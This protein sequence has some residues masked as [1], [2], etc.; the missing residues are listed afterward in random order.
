MD[1]KKIT[2]MDEASQKSSRESCTGG[3]HNGKK[4]GIIGAVLL[5]LIALIVGIGIYNTPSN[6]L[7]WQLDLGNR[8]LKEQNYEQAIVEF[9]KAIAID[10]VSVDAYLGKAEAYI[11]MGDQ[12]SALDT[13]QAGYDLTGDARL[14]GKLDEIEAQITQIKQA[15]EKARQAEEEARLAAEEETKATEAEEI[16]RLVEEKEEELFNVD[17][18]YGAWISDDIRLRFLPVTRVEELCRPLVELLEQYK[19]IY[20][21]DYLT[22]RYLSHY[23]YLLGEYEMCLEIRRQIHELQLMEWEQRGSD[24]ESYP[25]E[26][27]TEVIEIDR[28]SLTYT[29]DEYG[30]TIKIKGTGDNL[31]EYEYGE[32]GRIAQRVQIR[33]SRSRE[34]STY[35]YD[36][37]GRILKVVHNYNDISPFVG[38]GT[39]EFVFT[40][41]EKGVTEH[42]GESE[43]QYY[44]EIDEYGHITESYEIDEYGN[45]TKLSP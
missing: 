2:E 29:Y 33:G 25:Y 22:W 7:S 10:P 43:N 36:S 27:A 45:P 1:E 26:Y 38:S 40:Y 9:D 6:R 21:D 3:K 39:V 34:T 44:Y 5:I 18:L 15:E 32:N 42:V 37:L 41:D 17:G 19:E 13:L 14:K 28:A 30:R 24:P 16:K 23:Y 8:Y 11:G 20:T 31:D 35:E 4:L 12:Q